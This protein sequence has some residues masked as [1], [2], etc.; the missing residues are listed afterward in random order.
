ME[1]LP[2]LFS[3]A[4]QVLRMAVASAYLAACGIQDLRSRRISLRASAAAGF[5]AIALNLTAWITCREPVLPYVGGLLPGALLL[6]LAFFSDGAAGTG[7][8]ICFLVLGALLG[9]WQA[10]GLLMASLVPASACGV[11]LMAMHRAGRKTRLP[12]LTFTAAAWFCLAA[13]RLSGLDL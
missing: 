10:W 1:N 8:G 9:M 6:L 11:A 13:V 2:E 4:I 5:A 12:L 3:K 7:D